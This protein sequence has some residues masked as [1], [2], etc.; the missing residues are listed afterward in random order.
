MQILTYD[1]TNPFLTSVNNARL[2]TQAKKREEDEFNSTVPPYNGH[3]LED[4]MAS[5]ELGYGSET[6]I[7]A[8]HT[9]EDSIGTAALAN[10]M[11][12]MEGM[13]SSSSW[14]YDDK[15]DK[16]S[17][18]HWTGQHDEE[19]HKLPRARGYKLRP[20]ARSLRESDITPR[21][22]RATSQDL[23]DAQA[24]VEKALAESSML[25]VLRLA[26]PL[27][28]TYKTK[29]DA[30]LRVDESI[31]NDGVT[32]LLH[33]TTEIAEA[34]ALIAEADSVTAGGNST[35]R[36]VSTG[37]YW[38]GSLQ[39]KGTVPWGKSLCGPAVS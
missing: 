29:K 11:P 33:I 37:T 2:T 4:I 1:D 28:N 26:Q 9:F 3:T 25:N 35:K 7:H 36:A 16:I 18:D 15:L 14:S 21:L 27:R 13:R 5:I 19:S 20:T 39:R 10:E 34:A 32:P 8:N 22:K 31:T 24:I 6:P 38:M 23:E 30:N 12:Q 17:T